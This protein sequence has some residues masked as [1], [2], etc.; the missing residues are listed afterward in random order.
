MSSMLYYIRREQV[1]WVF[2]HEDI[3]SGLRSFAGMVEGADRIFVVSTDRE[4]LCVVGEI[5]VAE[6]Y[7]DE[8]FQGG[9]KYRVRAS[10]GSST[11]YGMPVHLKGLEDELTIL[12]GKSGIWNQVRNPRWLPATDADLLSRLGRGG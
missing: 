10:K 4:G 6:T 12:R 5:P 8:S 3:G 2:E 7:V 1:D 11:R 9:W